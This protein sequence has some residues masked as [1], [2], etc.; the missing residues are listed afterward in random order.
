MEVSAVDVRK[1]TIGVELISGLAVD[2]I[3]LI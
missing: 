3:G 1:T 2:L